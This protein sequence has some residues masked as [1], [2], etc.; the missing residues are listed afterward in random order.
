M[1]GLFAAFI[2]T[3]SSSAQQV[4]V[5]YL[6]KKYSISSSDLVGEVFFLQALTLLVLGPFLDFYL[7][8][9]FF[10]SWL[11]ALDS[12]KRVAYMAMSCSLAVMV[13]YSQ[14]R[15]TPELSTGNDSLT[16]SLTR[17][18]QFKCISEL[19]ATGMACDVNF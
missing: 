9:T 7:V 5:A 19:S 17:R 6:G 11:P 1:P 3:V 16:Q 4:G 14:V 15:A 18:S 8:H 12:A 13:N 2:A 10:T